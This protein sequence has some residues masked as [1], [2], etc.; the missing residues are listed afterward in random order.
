MINITILFRW[1]WWWNIMAHVFD[2]R[3]NPNA[4][5]ILQR[6]NF[7][8]NIS[9]ALVG[10]FQLLEGKS[11]GGCLMTFPSDI[12]LLSIFVSL[13]IIGAHVI[14]I[15]F[16]GIF[17]EFWLFKWDQF[18]LWPSSV[19]RGN[20]TMNFLE[21]HA[22]DHS[23]ADCINIIRV[24]CMGQE[25]LYQ[26]ELSILMARVSSPTYQMCF[27]FFFLLVASFEFSFGPINFE[28]KC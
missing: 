10:V 7:F 25:P 9:S 11:C 23:K 21:W 17:E 20:S 3:S 6:S 16:G 19:V 2:I 12:S 4:P 1:A 8:T 27:S 18:F 5:R 26:M 15:V 22:Y 24:G 13:S 14:S 28:T